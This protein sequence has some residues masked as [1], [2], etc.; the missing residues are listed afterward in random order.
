MNLKK[1]SVCEKRV[2]EPQRRNFKSS[3]PTRGRAA[4]YCRLLNERCSDVKSSNCRFSEK[5]IREN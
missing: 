5:I 4:A 2:L 1:C 3:F